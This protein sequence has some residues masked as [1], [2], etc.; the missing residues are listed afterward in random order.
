VNFA[1]KIVV[2]ISSTSFHLNP[3]SGN[4]AV[5]WGQTGRT[6]G[7]DVSLFATAFRTRL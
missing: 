4:P 1:A 7:H 3:S 5:L 6:D 2:K